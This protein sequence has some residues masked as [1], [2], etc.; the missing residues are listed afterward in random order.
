MIFYVY[1][2]PSIISLA[3]ATPPLGLQLLIG[4]LR[5]FLQN[6]LIAEFEDFQVQEAIKEQVESLPEIYERKEIKAIFAALAK[7]NRFIFC[8]LPDYTGRKD[9]F[10]CVIEQ[11]VEALIDLICVAQEQE[12]TDL[13]D[14]VEVTTFASYQ[15]TNFESN[16]SQLASNGRTWQEGDVDQGYFL[17]INFKKA[18]RFATQI[19]VCDRL[20][21][22]KFGDN[23]E[24]TIKIM[25]RWLESVLK[26][27]HQCKLV[28]HCQKPDGRTDEHMRTIISSFKFGRL[29]DLQTEIKFYQLPEDSPETHWPLPHDRFILTDQI[30]LQIGRGMD[31]LNQA[32]DLKFSYRETG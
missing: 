30:A 3:N 6:C 13:P 23:Y 27:P 2:D 11:A 1:F 18:L 15:N 19:N 14:G 28:F 10:A 12:H 22:E 5:G 4:I 24:Y 25:F 8:L 29:A 9:N 32:V 16:R 7:K 31:F 21:G 20:F 26:E 17:D